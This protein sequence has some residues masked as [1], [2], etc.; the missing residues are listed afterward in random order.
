MRKLDRGPGLMFRI[1]NWPALLLSAEL[2]IIGSAG[3][4]ATTFDSGLKQYRL[5]R[6][7]RAAL[8]FTLAADEDPDNALIHY[9]LADTFVRTQQ[10]ARAIKEY[11]TCYKLKPRGTVAE[12]CKKALSAYKH[13][14]PS[15]HRGAG[16]AGSAVAEY[17]AG[18]MPLKSD[19]DELIA[20]TKSL[21]R[22][23]LKLEKSKHQ[24]LYECYSQA[25]LQQAEKEMQ[26]ISEEAGREME[27]VSEPQMI[28][29]GRTV[30]YMP[31]DAEVARA[32]IEEIK[33][34]LAERSERVRGVAQAK[35]ESYKRWSRERQDSL[36]EVAANL[37][38]QLDEPVGPS[39]VKL[40]PIGTDLYT[41]YYG[42]VRS[43]QKA[44]GNR[45][46]V[47]RVVAPEAPAPALRAEVE[48]LPAQEQEKD[49]MHSERSVRGSLLH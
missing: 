11:G 16:T 2:V 30:R 48:R 44:F 24:Q 32:R 41:R 22:Q 28:M 31:P 3:W 25:A 13:P 7:D 1:N 40:Q 27:A 34:Q 39:G 23:E 17:L 12:Y 8:Y 5:G 46:P 42:S 35:A 21:I 14:L 15:L 4:C 10:H 19:Q 45:P 38:S 36:E 43:A 47:V 9:Y 29:L 20:R 26:K 37:E 18:S 6:Y 49:G 33:R